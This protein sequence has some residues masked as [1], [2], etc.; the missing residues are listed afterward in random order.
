VIIIKQINKLKRKNK[1]K[2]KMK[3]MKKRMRKMKIISIFQLNEGERTIL[4]V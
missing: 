3:K 2:I 4:F 1:V